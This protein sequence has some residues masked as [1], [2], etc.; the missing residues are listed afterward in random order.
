[1]AS[2][3]NKVGVDVELALDQTLTKSLLKMAQGTLDAAVI[4]PPAYDKS[5]SKA[6]APTRPWGT[7]ARPWLANVRS[8]FGFA[9][10][11]YHPVVW[12]DGPVQDWAQAK[13]KRARGA[14]GGRGQ[15]PDPDLGQDRFRL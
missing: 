5:S 4:P 10:S 14:A 8:L 6:K 1:M 7:R 12:A 2:V 3:W 9:A 15:R 11:V 13:G